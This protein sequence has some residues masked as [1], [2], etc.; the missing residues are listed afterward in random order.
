MIIE[1]LYGRSNLRLVLEG[2]GK[3]VDLG[4]PVRL[5]YNS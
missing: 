5:G 4:H 2:V 1:I 3:R